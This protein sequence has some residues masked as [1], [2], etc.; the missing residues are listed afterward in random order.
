MPFFAKALV[1]LFDGIAVLMALGVVWALVHRL[2]FGRPYLRFEDF[3]FVLGG[4]LRARLKP[5]R[6]LSRCERMT[7]I[8]RCVEV[9]TVVRGSGR[10]RTVETR[11]WQVY[12]DRQVLES[13]DGRY[14]V[15]VSFPLPSGEYAT[16][17]SAD[18]RTR[19][20]E[21]LV[22]A[23]VPGLDLRSAFLLPVYAP[24]G[25]GRPEPSS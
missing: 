18:T 8:L 10:S 2:K 15:P 23:Q 1:G 5:A 7:L 4:A 17:L 24:R 14:E 3:P 21:L 19:Y 20:W 16:Q 13:L 25:S 11:G 9:E 6:G 12:E 22:E